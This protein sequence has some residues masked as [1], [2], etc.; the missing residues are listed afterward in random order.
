MRNSIIPPPSAKTAVHN[1]A[2]KGSF[3]TADLKHFAAYP[4]V[5]KIETSIERASI[6]LKVP[7]RLMVGR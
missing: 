4:V 1:P 3:T 6:M 2:T 7:A 5:A